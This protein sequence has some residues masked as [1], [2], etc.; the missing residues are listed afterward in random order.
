MSRLGAAPR[1][2][3]F[4]I[5]DLGFER[6]DTGITYGIPAKRKSDASISNLSC[7]ILRQHNTR[8]IEVD[9]YRHGATQTA[10]IPGYGLRMW[11]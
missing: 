4:G 9:M 10:S 8:G 6:K 2:I 3:G 7:A 1:Q 5:E 11:S